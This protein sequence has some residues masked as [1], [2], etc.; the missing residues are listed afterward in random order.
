LNAV[1]FSA[2][3]KFLFLLFQNSRNAVLRGLSA[4][5]DDWVTSDPE[6]LSMEMDVH[7][8]KVM[9]GNYAFLT[10]SITGELFVRKYCELDAVLDYESVNVPY[11]VNLPRHS[12]YTRLFDQ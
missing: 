7:M 4:K 10:D 5:I 12:A 9:A 1:V 8:R 2:L 6:V 3:R 11:T